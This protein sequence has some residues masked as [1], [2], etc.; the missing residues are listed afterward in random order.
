MESGHEQSANQREITF[1]SWVDQQ[2]SEGGL[3]GVPS[4]TCPAAGKP[5]LPARGGEPTALAC[6]TTCAARAYR[7]TSLLPT[8]LR[9]GA[10]R[11]NGSPGSVP[12]TCTPE[13][14]GPARW[15]RALNRRIAEVAAGSPTGPP[16]IPA[17]GGR[18][19][20]MGR[21]G[22]RD[23]RPPA[24]PPAPATAP[25]PDPAPG[26]A[27][28][29]GPLAGWLAPPVRYEPGPFPVKGALKGRPAFSSSWLQRDGGYPGMLLDD[30]PGGLGRELARRP[31]RGPRPNAGQPGHARGKADGL[32]P[33]QAQAV[34]RRC[35]WL[36][37]QQL[38]RLA[39]YRSST[40]EPGGRGS[41][42]APPRWPPMDRCQ[43][44]RAQ[45]MPC[46]TVR[47][48]RRM[49]RRPV[50]C[51]A[52]ELRVGQRHAAQQG[53]TMAHVRPAPPQGRPPSANGQ[54]RSPL[55]PGPGPVRSQRA[56][57]GTETKRFQAT[58]VSAR[59]G[60]WPPFTGGGHDH[61]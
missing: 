41:A 50:R 40:E 1:A 39:A 17:P 13:D 19:T 37:G 7:P 33:I 10:R 47:G 9:P 55:G 25:G 61:G 29:G 60:R 52:A 14:E 49:G 20:A 8:P 6:R 56:W 28:R 59:P 38:R 43:P 44:A 36:P 15:S 3:S 11:P 5:A 2:V 48:P 53:R 26:S 4:I 54:P 18:G 58:G 22:W 34:P 35:A 23:G 32:S 12:R 45:A 51:T 46:G 21:P 24:G 42:G 31:P 30:R 57:P 27:R 16:I